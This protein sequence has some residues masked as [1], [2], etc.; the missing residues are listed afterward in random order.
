MTKEV[1]RIENR[2]TLRACGVGD[3]PYRPEAEPS[4]AIQHV[5][6]AMARRHVGHLH[7]SPR[8]DGEPFDLYPEIAPSGWDENPDLFFGFENMYQLGSWYTDGELCMLGDLGY[9]I[10]VY[11]VQPEDF[12]PGKSQVCF[13]HP[14]GGAPVSTMDPRSLLKQK[15]IDHARSLIQHDLDTHYNDPEVENTYTWTDKG[16]VV[17]EGPDLRMGRAA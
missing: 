9:V 16:P 12:F 1:Y 8:A 5:L 15:T 13:R 4:V 14:V 10:S 17:K 11:R 6:S 2:S 7:P 3:G